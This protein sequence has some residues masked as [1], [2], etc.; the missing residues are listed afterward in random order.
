M[1]RRS[2]PKP[3]PSLE[4]LSQIEQLVK[5]RSRN[6]VLTKLKALWEYAYGT[7]EKLAKAVGC[8]GSSIRNWIAHRSYPSHKMCSK[9]DQLFALY[10][11]P[12]EIGQITNKRQHGAWCSK[13]HAYEQEIGLPLRKPTDRRYERETD[14]RLHPVVA[15]CERAFRLG[16]GVPRNLITLYDEATG[17]QQ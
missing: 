13:R 3:I 6:V 11:T 4:E 15:A 17:T 10:L 2:Q 1:K 8:D 16:V 14:S 12:R 7:Q 5:L 9:I